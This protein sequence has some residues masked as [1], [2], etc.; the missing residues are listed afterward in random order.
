[1][2]R[3]EAEI[4]FQVSTEAMLPH[5]RNPASRIYSMEHV[6]CGEE[7]HEECLKKCP[8]MS[9]KPAMLCTDMKRN[10]LEVVWKFNPCCQ[11]LFI[12]LAL[13]YKKHYIAV[14]ATN[15]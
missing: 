11:N 6:Y 3:N 5:T 7:Q 12:T 1:M 2:S 8:Q 9:R 10:F 13:T 4:I 14:Q 15:L